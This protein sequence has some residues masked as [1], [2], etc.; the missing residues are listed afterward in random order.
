MNAIAKAAEQVCGAP[1]RA[2]RINADGE[3]FHHALA[4]TAFRHNDLVAM[5]AE[6]LLHQAI[7]IV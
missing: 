1:F 5:L 7:P 2:I 4:P 6:M 3:A